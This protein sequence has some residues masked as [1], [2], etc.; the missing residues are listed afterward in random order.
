MGIRGMGQAVPDI[1]M[2]HTLYALVFH[3]STRQLERRKTH[4]GSSNHKFQKLN[5][6]LN[7]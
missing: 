4:F 5:T 1:F 7:T 2:V 3:L 6:L